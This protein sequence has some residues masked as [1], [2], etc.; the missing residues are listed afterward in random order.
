MKKTIL[1]IRHSRPDFP[2]G[3]HLCLGR[4]NKIGLCEEGRKKA[5]ALKEWL[6][7]DIRKAGVIY[8][9]PLKRTMETARIL[10]GDLVPV[11]PVEG[12]IEMDA[13]EWDGLDFQ[14][15]RS[16][17][18][19]LFE[20]RGEDMSIPPPGGETFAEASLRMRRAFE[21][22]AEHTE[23]DLLIAVA[24]SG[25]NRAF[26]CDL[27]GTAYKDNRTIPQN[28]NSVSTILFDTDTKAFECKEAG[29]EEYV[30]E[31]V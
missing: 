15:I 5:L 30:H 28:Y 1:L 16:R 7:R 6:K 3:I 14:T 9:S 29:N 11:V 10:A 17:Y 13:G 8:A 22:L 2:G 4:D 26:L 20:K 21:E 24:H 27:T 23:N 19:E 18:P 12:L 31:T 25:I